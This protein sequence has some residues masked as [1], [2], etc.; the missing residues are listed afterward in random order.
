MVSAGWRGSR[1]RDRT[2][3]RRRAAGKERRGSAPGEVHRLVVPLPRQPRLRLLLPIISRTDAFGCVAMKKEGGKGARIDAASSRVT[4]AARA[5]RRGAPSGNGREAVAAGR[6]RAVRAGPR[7]A[8]RFS[9]RRARASHARKAVPNAGACCAPS[10]PRTVSRQGSS[11]SLRRADRDTAHAPLNPSVIQSHLVMVQV[12]RVLLIEWALARA[13]AASARTPHR[14]RVHR[15][16][17][18]RRTGNDAAP[19]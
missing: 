14:L 11:S 9:A 5:R 6:G 3:L 8:E 15:Q 4:H 19:G 10:R 2:V 18:Q 16:R 17:R 1:C 12:P 13:S 7:S